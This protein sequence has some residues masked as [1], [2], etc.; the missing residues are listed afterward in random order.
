MIQ[1]TLTQ[2]IAGITVILEKK[3]SVFTKDVRKT[4][5]LIQLQQMQITQNFHNLITTITVQW[6]SNK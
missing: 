4:Q 5:I 2:T 3:I 6:N 1:Q